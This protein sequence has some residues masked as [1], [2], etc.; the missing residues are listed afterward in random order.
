MQSA[1]KDIRESIRSGLDGPEKMREFLR[2]VNSA[3]RQE[4][5]TKTFRL[6]IRFFTSITSLL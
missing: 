6:Q 4:I 2:D 1:M 5:S 3:R